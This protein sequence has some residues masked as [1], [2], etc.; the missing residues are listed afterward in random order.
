MSLFTR[1]A[2]VTTRASLAP[3]AGRTSAV[4]A[5][6]PAFFSTTVRREDR[7]PVEATK[8]TLKKA[9]KAVSGA[10]VRGIESSGTSPVLFL[11]PLSFFVP[12]SSRTKA[13][14]GVRL[15]KKI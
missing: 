4:A 3:L 11:F 5:G 15:I 14:V 7:G 12:A 10:A 6:R 1:I 8:E 9:D 13:D 2:P